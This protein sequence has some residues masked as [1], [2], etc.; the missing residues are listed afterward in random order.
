MDIKQLNYFIT[1]VEEG[2]ISAAAARLHISQ[3]P[4][5]T[6]LKVLEKELGVILFER[7]PRS[8]TLTDAGRL[9]Y[10]RAKNL[11]SLADSIQQEMAD[12]GNGLQGLLRI[13]TIS[14]SAVF[15]LDKCV[16][17]F[18]NKYPHVRFDVQEGNT[19]QLIDKLKAGNIE[20]AVVRTPFKN[21]GFGCVYAQKE[22]MTAVGKPSFFESLPQPT[23]ALSDLA[24]RPLIYYRRFEQLLFTQFSRCGIEPNII[25]S[26]DDARTSLLWSNAGLG[27]ALVPYSISQILIKPEL[28]RRTL[29]DQALCTQIALIWKQNQYLSNS[30]KGFIQV[31]EECC[32]YK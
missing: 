26:N 28:E 17:N 8:I 6:Q 14:S 23:I 15:L 25:C 11:T 21:E 7:G 20:L 5:S 29:S 12:F 24:D 16:E 3:P 31:F 18:H 9:L 19:F 32:S 4:L 10:N 22:P 13:G 2:S 30:G 27:V 1:T